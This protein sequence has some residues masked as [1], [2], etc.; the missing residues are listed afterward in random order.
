MLEK[1]CFQTQLAALELQNNGELQFC[2]RIFAANPGFRMPC[3]RT[4]AFA[5]KLHHAELR[6]HKN[7][8][9]WSNYDSTI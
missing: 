6:V 7:Y 9:A 2:P 1:T 3:F 8:F 4:F 5:L